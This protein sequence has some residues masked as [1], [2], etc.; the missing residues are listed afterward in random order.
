MAITR[1]ELTYAWSS[2]LKLPQLQMAQTF[3]IL[4]DPITHEQ[5]LRTATAADCGRNLDMMPVNGSALPAHFV[6]FSPRD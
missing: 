2:A 1:H 5:T 3:M 4:A 6:M